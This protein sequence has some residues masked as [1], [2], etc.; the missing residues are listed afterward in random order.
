VAIQAVDRL[1]A[2]SSREGGVAQSIEE[3]DVVVLGVGTCGEEIGL[4]LAAAGLD[5]VGIEDH[6]VGGECAYWA[7]IPSKMMIRAANLL[8]EARRVDGVAGH[9]EVTP[10]WAPVAARIR[11][12]ASG[13]WDD[14]I[15]V[16]RFEAHGGRIVHGRGRFVAP[17]T[18][19]VGEQTF[20]ARRGVVLSTGSEPIVPPVPGLSNVDY[21]TSHDAIQASHLPDSLIV[22]GGGAVGCELGQVFARFG[23]GVTIVDGHDRLLAAEEPEASA[24]LET[25]FAAE[26]IPVHTGAHATRVAADGGTIR[27]TLSDGAELRADRLLVATG[28]RVNLDGLGLES[29]GIDASNGLAVDANLLAGEGVW[30]VGDVAGRGFFTHLALAQ[31]TIVEDAI[32]GD[33]SA[34]VA[35]G[36][37]GR[38]GAPVP[39]VTFTDPEVASV[40]LSESA[41]R[42]AGMDVE[43]ALKDVAA[44]FRGWLHGPGNLGL[45][46]LVADRAGGTLVGATVVGPHAG[47]V[48]GLLNLAV[49]ARVPLT[50]LRGMVYP[51]PT[52]HGAVGE[53]L[54]AYGRALTGV[55]DPDVDRRLQG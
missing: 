39:R 17:R 41:A 36:G 34:G 7:C 30:V 31:A 27:M 4:R 3:V 15:A 19:Q 1:E 22:L 20:R 50:R 35:P 24:V 10:D 40:G 33:G 43:V 21:W 37:D 5:V 54:G 28:R 16:G 51:F 38:T 45:V 8:A 44:T 49:H 42:D 26:G 23:V 29:I 11:A 6:L 9:A 14:T 2:V 25:A 46:K 32:L 55:L 18:V 53:V 13:D 52:F 48:L 12:E 47:E